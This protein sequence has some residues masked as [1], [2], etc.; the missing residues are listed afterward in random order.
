MSN[1]HHD[2]D[3]LAEALADAWVERA[4]TDA[5]LRRLALR[6][7]G[8]AKPPAEMT[9]AELAREHGTSLRSL[10]RLET[11]VLTKLRHHPAAIAALRSL[12]PHNP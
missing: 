10:H 8:L 12:Y 6:A 1:L 11:N 9:R 5:A 7:A 4:M 2:D 3:A